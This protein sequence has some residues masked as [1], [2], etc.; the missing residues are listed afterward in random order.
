[1]AARSAT[2]T[3]VASSATAVQLVGKNDSRRSDASG[4]S[5]VITN[6]STAILYI[7]LGPDTPSASNFTYA[8]PAIGA[9][10]VSLEIWGFRGPVQGIW[11]AANG[12]ATV[13]EAL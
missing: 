3:P 13:T 9:A 6:N 5:L 10:P 11:A 1:M 4:P 12:N 2:T 8:L 7:T